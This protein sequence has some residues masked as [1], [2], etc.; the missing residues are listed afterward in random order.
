[1]TLPA[2]LLPSEKPAVYTSLQGPLLEEEAQALLGKVSP[3]AR[4]HPMA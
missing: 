3:D 2:A 1:M 4:R